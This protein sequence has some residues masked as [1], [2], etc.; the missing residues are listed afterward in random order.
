MSTRFSNDVQAIKPTRPFRILALSGGGYRGLFTAEVLAQIEE[1]LKLAPL[2]QH[3]DLIAGTSVG[4]LIATGLAIGLPAS[5]VRNAIRTYG[6]LIFDDRYQ[7]FGKSIPLRKTRGPLGGLVRSKFRREPLQLAIKQILTEKYATSTV[8]QVPGKLILVA[9]CATRN[10][11]VIISSIEPHDRLAR[12]IL[13]SQALLATSAAPTYF[14]AVNMTHDR[15]LDSAPRGADT[16]P[17]IRSLVDGGLVANAPDL[18]ALTETLLHRMAAL[19]HCHVLSVGTAAEDPAGV[20]RAIGRRGLVGW[21]RGLV[22]LIMSAQE[23]LIV[24]QT[25]ALLGE[26]FFRINAR[27]SRAEAA[28]I[29]LDLATPAATATLTSLALSAM[30]QTNERKLRSFFGVVE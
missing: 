16:P 2:G 27:P 8:S 28:V 14:P 9:T 3:F 13:L 23:T 22:P 10:A 29:D 15:D 24:H 21:A 30:D 6:P 1:R 19:E 25:Q 7:L 12:E 26:R 11:P 4:G 17:T 5:Q 18:V 20:P